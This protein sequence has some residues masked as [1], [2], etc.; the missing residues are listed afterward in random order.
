MTQEEISNPLFVKKFKHRYSNRV[1]FHEVDSFGVVHNIQ[2][3][4]FLEIAHTDY[5]RELGIKFHPEV[6][7]LDLPVVI[8]HNEIDYFSSLKFD[9]LYRVLT[10]VSYFKNSSFEMQS[11]IQN[12]NDKLVAFGK[13]IFVHLNSQTLQPE[14]IPKRILEL[15]R[16][17]ERDDVEQ[18]L[19]FNGY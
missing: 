10:R 3:F 6:F 9:N 8:V 2:Y 14:P 19:G 18:H 7:L 16:S 1:R 11:I 4:Y 12:E 15:I 5:F 13:T 17:F